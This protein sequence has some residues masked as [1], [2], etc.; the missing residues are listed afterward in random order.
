MQTGAVL[1]H[2]HFDAGRLLSLI[3]ENRIRGART[4]PFGFGSTAIGYF[5]EIWTHGIGSGFL[6]MVELR[7][8]WPTNRLIKG[9]DRR[10]IIKIRNQIGNQQWKSILVRNKRTIWKTELSLKLN[11]DQLDGPTRSGTRLRICWSIWER[12]EKFQSGPQQI[13]LN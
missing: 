7:E 12:V 8:N 2:T 13:G 5:A 11:S 9:R 4:G 6:A 1:P 10:A 3:R